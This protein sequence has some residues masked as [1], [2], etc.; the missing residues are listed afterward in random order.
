VQIRKNPACVDQCVETVETADD[1][2]ESPRKDF[3]LEKFKTILAAPDFPALTHS[4]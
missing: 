4:H 1:F 2:L 3:D